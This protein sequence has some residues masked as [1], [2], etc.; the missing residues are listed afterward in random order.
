MTLR[1]SS[2][3]LAAPFNCLF[4]I[5]SSRMRASSLSP[6]HKLEK[7]PFAGS[8][9]GLEEAAEYIHG[10]CD[11]DLDARLAGVPMTL[12]ATAGVAAQV[13]RIRAGAPGAEFAASVCWSVHNT[14]KKSVDDCV[15]FF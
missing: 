5:S 12:L 11:G 13:A 3:L 4:S 7:L 9:G 15:V 2:R 8:G 10:V 6:A 1:I 14:F